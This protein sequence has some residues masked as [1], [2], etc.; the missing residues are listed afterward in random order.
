MNILYSYSINKW[1]INQKVMVLYYFYPMIYVLFCNMAAG[2][3]LF[4]NMAAGYVLFCNMAAGCSISCVSSIGKLL[5]VLMML[6]VMFNNLKIETIKELRVLIG[7]VCSM[8]Y[9]LFCSVTR[10][11]AVSYLVSALLGNC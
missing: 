1:A 10:L 2:Y 7:C 9:E 11:L 6:L 8:Q 3:V 5:I 4:C